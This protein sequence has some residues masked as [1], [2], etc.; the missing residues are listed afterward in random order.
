VWVRPYGG[1]VTL[2]AGTSRVSGVRVGPTGGLHIVYADDLK[3]FSLKAWN[4]YLEHPFFTALGSGDLER[5]SFRFWLEQDLPYVDVY[6]QVR[7]V[8]AA[9]LADDDR[10]SDLLPE[11]DALW[12]TLPGTQETLFEIEMLHLLGVEA[13]PVDRFAARRSRDGYMN[14]LTQV[15]IDGSAAHISAAMLPCEW[16]FT[17]MGRRLNATRSAD[18]D[19]IYSKWIDY[20]VTE[21]Q[22]RNTD[23]SLAAYER[24]AEIASPQ[25]R[26]ECKQIFLRSVRH[27]ILVLDAAWHAVDPWPDETDDR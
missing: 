25:E 16:G 13:G 10:Y 18:L 6:G 17:E 20:Y 21:G 5:K 3:L 1:L 26:E 27:Q 23:V 4:L 9:K 14:H 11:I 7:D 22:V 24:A 19:P 12:K 2:S 8:L 15:A